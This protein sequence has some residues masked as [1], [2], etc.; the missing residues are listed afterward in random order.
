MPLSRLP[1]SPAFSWGGYECKIQREQLP[2][3]SPSNVKTLSMCPSPMDVK[4]S[5]QFYIKMYL[6]LLLTDSHS[7]TSQRLKEKKRKL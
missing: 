1:L 2:E 4:S 7:E 5:L 6:F 3:A